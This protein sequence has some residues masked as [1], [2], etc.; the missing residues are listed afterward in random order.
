MK[1]N[2][3]RIV[4]FFL[5][6]AMLVQP[7]GAADL[8]HGTVDY[9]ITQ[10]M[11]N[12]T[13][14]ANYKVEASTQADAREGK[15]TAYFLEDQIQT[16]SIEIEENNLN[17]LLQNAVE[18]PYVMAKSVTI[19]GVTLGY[20][21]LRT[22]GNYTLAHS[23]WDNAGS[24]RFSFTV[25]FGHYINK[26]AG[27]PERQD[28]YGCDKISFNNFFF[29]KS[30]MKEF[31]ALKLMEE[32]GLPTPRY[33]LAKLYINGEYY[34]VYAMIENMDTP[35]LERYYDLDSKEL[36]SYLTKPAQT[37]LRYEE[38]AE[39]ASPLWEY[40]EEKRLE[41]EDMLPTATEWVRR[42]NCLSAGT[43]FSGNAVD[44]N[45]EEYLALLEQVLNVDEV[46]RYFA[47]HSW[48]CQMDNM[49]TERQNFGLYISPEGVATIVPWDY[50]LSFGCYYPSTAQATANF[51]IDVMYKLGERVYDREAEMSEQTYARFPL[52]YV[53]YQNDALMERYHSYM[54][55]C[56]R[57][58]ALGG[59][60]GATGKSYDPGYF[61]SYIQRMQETV[62]QA[63]SEDLAENVYYMNR[64]RQP[65]DVKNALPN[66]SRIIALRAVGVYAQV[67]DLDTTVSAAGCDLETL[68]NGSWGWTA[69]SGRLTL[70]D[71]ATGI[72]ATAE[73][74]EEERDADDRG[75]WGRRTVNGLGLTVNVLE[76]GNGTY[77]AIRE[78]VGSGDTLLVYELSNKK[79]ALGGYTVTIPVAGQYMAEGVQKRFYLWRDGALTE[80]EAAADDNLYTVAVE[81]LGYIAVVISGVSTG[82]N[83]A[84]FVVVA[85]AA[86]ATAA[87]VLLLRRKKKAE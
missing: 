61:A 12:N 46:V 4:L 58:A 60:V 47:A 75:G 8:S 42:L 6:C 23:A 7:A 71:A 1:K 19:G 83:G 32:M 14:P 3:T 49:F 64:I 68:G 81:N 53:I 55:D 59:T 79:A 11:V 69:S 26:A 56:S 16:V 48:L 9:E 15:Y 18:E 77:D 76:S 44:V 38:I 82:N 73:F 5:V 29:D 24:D 27:Y 43:D 10:D 33:G 86:A 80:L 70:V 57:V 52:F 87:A 13:P 22:K 74:A 37:N 51:P 50:D 63:A 41:V 40:D 84:V 30:M 36:S 54:L 66:L 17:Y 65:Q 39:D 28:F 62:V 20:C 35:I 85:A 2:L 31:F 21:G 45:S 67:M 78:A 25:N 72:F 34:G